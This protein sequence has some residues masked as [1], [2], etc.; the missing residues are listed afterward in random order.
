MY[1]I[2]Q[3]TLDLWLNYNYIEAERSMRLNDGGNEQ[4]SQWFDVQRAV[5]VCVCVGEGGGVVLNVHNCE[6]VEQYEAK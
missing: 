5:C 4:W 2:E 6:A 3:F 1:T